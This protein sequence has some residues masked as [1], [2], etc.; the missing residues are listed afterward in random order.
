MILQKSEFKVIQRNSDKTL[1]LIPGWATDY[2]IFDT[3]DLPY[4]YLMPVEPFLLGFEKG[5][6]EALD[7]NGLD[8][9]SILGWSLGGFLAAGF[10]SRHRDRVDE[11]ILVGIK[12]RYEGKDI[13][14]IKGYIRETRRGWLYKFYSEYFSNGEQETFLNFKKG[15]MRRYLDEMDAGSLVAGLDYLAGAE[16]KPESLKA[17][18][19]R[20]VHGEEDRIA[21]IDEARRLCEE[22]PGAEFI[23]VEGAGHMPFLTWTKI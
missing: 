15:L 12:R 1:L 23:T 17:L 14:K 11:L 21:P 19:V 3:L 6:L 2:R 16:I 7:E 13:E 9:I 18:K 8:K 4:N 10:A 20:F 5:L 22:L